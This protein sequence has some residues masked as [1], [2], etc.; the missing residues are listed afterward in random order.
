MPSGS[1]SYKF[2]V[3]VSGSNSSAYK[4]YEICYVVGLKKRKAST[5][6]YVFYEK[7]RLK[8]DDENSSNSTQPTNDMK[9]LPQVHK[10]TEKSFEN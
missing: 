5:I 1:R 10:N 8:M 7:R 4:T 3:A 6:V 2:S 9:Q